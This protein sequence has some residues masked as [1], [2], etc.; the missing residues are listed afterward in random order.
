MTAPVDDG[1]PQR[2]APSLSGML[3]QSA[4]TTYWD[5]SLASGRTW[6]CKFDELILTFPELVQ[7]QLRDEVLGIENDQGNRERLVYPMRPPCPMPSGA[8]PVEENPDPF[9]CSRAGKI[10]E[11][12]ILSP[13]HLT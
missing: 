3:T 9:P 5:Q 13:G 1:G 2:M 10:G 4:V 6:V 11:C 7:S 8:S 12:D